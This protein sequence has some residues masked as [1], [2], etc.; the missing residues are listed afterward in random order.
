MDNERG[1]T[2]GDGLTGTDNGAN[3]TFILALGTPGTVSVTSVNL[4][5]GGTHYHDVETSS[6]P[7]ATS[8]ILATADDGGVQ[9]L[10]L[11]IGTDPDTDNA[12]KVANNTYV[13]IASNDIR[14]KFD[15]SSGY[16]DAVLGDAAGSDRLRVVDSGAVEVA[17]IDS[18]G[19]AHFHGIVD[20]YPA[21]LR[22]I[23]SATDVSDPPTD[24]EIDA[25]FG[26]PATVGEGFIGIIVSET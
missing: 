7:G 11:G 9:L 17:Y 8:V 1:L 16:I 22:T 13:G 2:V 20:A 15:G 26:A 24:A 6:N 10:R 25:I 5:T 4:A 14:I 3:S 12:V 21:G 18:N 23:V 19:A